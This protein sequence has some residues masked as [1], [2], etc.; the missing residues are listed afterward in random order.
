MD[1][2]GRLAAL[3][4]QLRSG[5]ISDAHLEQQVQELLDTE[6]ARLLARYPAPVVPPGFRPSA[7]DEAKARLAEQAK[8]YVEFQE[9]RARL[10]AENH[11]RF[12]E[13]LTRRRRLL[14]DT[15]S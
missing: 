2:E 12:V 3:Y 11:R 7:G 6:R 1:F 14:K 4:T 8:R 9:G 13:A 5:Q 10:Y 15:W